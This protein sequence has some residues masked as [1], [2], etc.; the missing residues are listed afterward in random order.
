MIVRSTGGTFPSPNTS[1]RKPS[2]FFGKFWLFPKNSTF[3]L[4]F[5]ISVPSG[6]VAQYTSSGLS[7][8]T[9]TL[10]SDTPR[11]LHMSTW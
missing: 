4:F 7:G 10:I 11:A 9:S 8:V 6:I 1:V 3:P 2:A 5:T